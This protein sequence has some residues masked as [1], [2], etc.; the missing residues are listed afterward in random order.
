ML[1]VSLTGCGD[2]VPS[3]DITGTW[4]VT[5]ADGMDL[6]IYN[7]AQASIT[8]GAYDGYGFSSSYSMAGTLA[9]DATGVAELI[10]IYSYSNFYDLGYGHESYGESC[11]Y[12]YQGMSKALDPRRFEIRFDS[13][14]EVCEDSDGDEYGDSG[15]AEMNLDCVLH[16]AHGVLD[17]IDR[18]EGGYWAFERSDTK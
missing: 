14:T 12:S 2:D 11:T 10:G 16:P 3:D 15:P 6:P 18:T 9:I 5:V 4:D 8:G 1:S 7:Y 13:A 17:C